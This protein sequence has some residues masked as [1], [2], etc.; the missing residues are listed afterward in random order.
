MDIYPVDYTTD[1]GRVR[2]Y[3]PDIQ[4]FSD[5]KDPTSPPEYMWS[6]DSIQSFLDD[7][8][9]PLWQTGIPAPRS[10]IWRAAANIMI[11]TANNENLVMKKIVTEDLETDGPSVAKAML[12][13]AKALHDRA[14][15]EDGL[16][17]VEEV[18]YSVDYV[19]S[20]PRYDWR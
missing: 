10:A 19:H 15:A 8:L 11:A 12:A 18:F 6:D 1:V 14:D 13:S 17:N 5:P 7:D 4:R 9:P 16:E 2:K 20:P 3:I